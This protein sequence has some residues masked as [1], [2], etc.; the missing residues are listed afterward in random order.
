MRNYK[1]TLSNHNAFTL[2]LKG[3]SLNST[4]SRL[5]MSS[6]RVRY[7][8]HSE[9]EL[10]CPLLYRSLIKG[11]ISP[12]LAELRRHAQAFLDSSDIALGNTVPKQIKKKQ[13][14]IRNQRTIASRQRTGIVPM[15]R[16]IFG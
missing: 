12:S 7:A 5:G 8:L 1:T 9:C 4:A 10:K 14:I 15:L 16:R 13:P 3:T 2:T 6:G 11:G